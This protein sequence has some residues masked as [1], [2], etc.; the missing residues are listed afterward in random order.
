[1]GV[2]TTV[3]QIRVLPTPHH[4]VFANVVPNHTSDGLTVLL[5]V[6]GVPWAVAASSSAVVLAAVSAVPVPSSRVVLAGTGPLI[7]V[8]YANP[9]GLFTSLKSIVVVFIVTNTALGI[10][11]APSCVEE[12]AAVSAPLTSSSCAIPGV[13]SVGLPIVIVIDPKAATMTLL[14]SP[15]VVHPKV[16][17]AILTAN[18][19]P[20]I[21]GSIGPGVIVNAFR[22]V[23]A[24]E[25]PAFVFA[26]LAGC[27]S[28]MGL[29]HTVMQFF[30]IVLITT[31]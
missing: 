9:V 22:F 26:F 19:K 18:G 17:L 23:N 3:S 29:I 24:Q 2:G 8:V 10:L 4:L 1:L 27:G 12:P 31:Y 20:S 16:S 7:V 30:A 11:P 21:V 14:V 15:V 28:K 5:T 25:D 13:L 6:V